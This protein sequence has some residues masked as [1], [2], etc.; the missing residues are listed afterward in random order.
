MRWMAVITLM[1]V[2]FVAHAKPRDK[3]KS[4]LFLAKNIDNLIVDGPLSIN[5]DSQDS[6]DH[7]HV[8]VP[9]RKNH[10]RFVIRGR[11]LRI[12]SSVKI[13]VSIHVAHLNSLVVSGLAEVHVKHIEVNRLLLTANH[14]A[15]VSLE[16]VDGL[17]SITNNGRGELR[18]SF[19]EFNRI[20]VTVRGHSVT[21]MAGLGRHMTLD[22]RGDS[23]FDGMFLRTD[24]VW[25]DARHTAV[26]KLN[27]RKLLH[28]YGQDSAQVAYYHS[29][30]KS[31]VY[32][33]TKGSAN[34]MAASPA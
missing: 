3:G 30:P 21:K 31:N 18:I 14:T 16:Q 32:Q 20:A 1:L 33:Q 15:P 9:R 34:V 8:A 24:D 27:P 23:L 10:A 12:K 2:P 25:V 13:P 22:A 11:T 29:M 26:V 5:I 28:A 7:M 19:V 6:D 4:T 17:R